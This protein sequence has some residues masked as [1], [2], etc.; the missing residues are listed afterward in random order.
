[1]LLFSGQVLPLPLSVWGAVQQDWL[2]AGIALLALVL[3]YA[4]RLA[5]AGLYGQSWR[6]AALHPV[7][8]LMTLVLQWWA[9]LRKIAGRPATWKQRAYKVG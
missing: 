9:L 2:I 5:M 6:G 3:G 7:G 1:M 4:A 8:V